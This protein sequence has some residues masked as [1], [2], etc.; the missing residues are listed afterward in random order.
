MSDTSTVK[1]SKLSREHQAQGEPAES[2]EGKEI[3]VEQAL[4]SKP[5]HWTGVFSSKS[6]ND[7]IDSILKTLLVITVFLGGFEYFSRQQTARVEKSLA[8]VDEWQSGPSAAMQRINDLIWPLY[9]PLAADIEA[10]SGDPAMRARLLGNIGDA[11]T[12]RDEDFSSAADRDVDTV[13]GFFDRAGLCANE[14]ICDYDVLATFLGDAAEP[15]W[16]YFAVYAE[17]RRAAGYVAYGAWTERFAR[18][19]IR[20]S[21]FGVV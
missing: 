16:L 18:G 11:V 13:F 6:Y 12:G 14:R 9:S 10:A 8:L 7:V 21:W 3:A 15:F 1:P 5:R 2:G 4:A 20:R 17:K 19:E